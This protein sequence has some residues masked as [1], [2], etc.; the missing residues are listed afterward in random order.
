MSGCVEGGL[1]QF[2]GCRDRQKPRGWT[3]AKKVE[4]G[5]GEQTLEPLEGSLMR[6]GDLLA[7]RH[8]TEG[9]NMPPS[10]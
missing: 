7:S 4:D 1:F 2:G 9:V 3:E 5:A 10:N 6:P 8:K